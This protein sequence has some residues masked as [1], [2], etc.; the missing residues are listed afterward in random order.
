MNVRCFLITKIDKHDLENIHFYAS[1]DSLEWLF[2]TSAI[3][4]HVIVDILKQL[5]K[6]GFRWL[7]LN[8]YC[9]LRAYIQLNEH[10]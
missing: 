8:E 9:C 7:L 4:A 1:P 2:Y 5:L 6:G 3:Q 10:V